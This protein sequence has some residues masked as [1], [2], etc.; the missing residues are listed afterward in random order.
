M[1]STSLFQH[2]FS[3]YSFSRS[4]T[5]VIPL[6]SVMYINDLDLN[7]DNMIKTSA[8]DTQIGRVVDVNK[9][10]LD[11]RKISMVWSVRQKNCK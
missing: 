5:I 7:T 3:V 11:S 1:F 6:H 9:K 2:S 4:P 10:S 8:N